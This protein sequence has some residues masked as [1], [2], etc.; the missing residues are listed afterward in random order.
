MGRPTRLTEHF[1]TVR[2]DNQPPRERTVADAIVDLIRLGNYM[3][4]AALYVGVGVSTVKLWLRDGS[5]ALD[6]LD[7]GAKRRDLSARQRHCGDFLAAVR[8]AQSEAE[9]RDVGRLAMLARGGIPLTRT[10]ERWVT[11]DDGQERLVER[12]TVTTETLPNM[13]A[14]AWRLER[15]FPDRWARKQEAEDDLAGDTEDDEFGEDPVQDALAALI[16]TERRQTEGTAALVSAGLE[17]IVDA[18]IVD[19]RPPEDQ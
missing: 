9:Q 7:S 1:D 3:E 16:D 4:T 15:R 10:T 14:I 8:A 11:D 12:T 5:R 19:E 6:R 17:D 18:E 13:A 2:A